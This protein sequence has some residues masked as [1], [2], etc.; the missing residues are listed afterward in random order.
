M[1]RAVGA[2]D[3]LLGHELAR[4]NEHDHSPEFWSLVGRAMPD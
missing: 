1:W 2:R 3:Y 4:L